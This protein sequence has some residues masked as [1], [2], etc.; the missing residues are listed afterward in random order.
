MVNRFHVQ[1]VGH[2]GKGRGS[3]FITWATRGEFSH[4][5]V[6]FRNIPFAIQD[7]VQ[8]D[9]HITIFDDYEIESIQHLGVHGQLFVPSPNQTIFNFEH[10]VIQ[11]EAIFFAI[12]NE[13]GKKYDWRG[14][15]GFFTRRNIQNPNKW[16]CSELASY[17]LRQAGIVCMNMPDHWLTPNVMLASP[18][19]KRVSLD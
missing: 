14:I 12:L 9:Y 15:G 3:R 17:G 19:L 8:N 1:V 4:V 13:C 10:T 18:V 2:N 6:R 11:A 5:S 7:A 16:F